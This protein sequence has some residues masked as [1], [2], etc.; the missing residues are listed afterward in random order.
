M[1]FRIFSKPVSYALALLAGIL[2]PD[3]HLRI[4]AVSSFMLLC[5]IPKG[6]YFSL[7]S[8][9]TDRIIPSSIL[10][11]SISRFLFIRRYL[12]VSPSLLWY[13]VIIAYMNYFCNNS[14][15]EYAKYFDIIKMP[16]RIIRQQR[17]CIFSFQLIKLTYSGFG[18]NATVN[19]K[20]H[21]A[22]P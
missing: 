10:I 9:S 4:S 11:E 3:H 12:I 19:I 21:N 15:G 2:L 16:L 7:I 13:N 17:H 18:S 20:L 6:R 22:L 14:F 5:E 1:R 8:S